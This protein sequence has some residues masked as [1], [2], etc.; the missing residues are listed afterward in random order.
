MPQFEQ[1]KRAMYATTTD[2]FLFIW[3]D[4]TKAVVQ[5]VLTLIFFK[6]PLTSSQCQMSSYT[7]RI[8]HAKITLL[9]L[10]LNG[11]NKHMRDPSMRPKTLLGIAPLVF[12]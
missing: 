4:T 2:L 3:V 7:I 12:S 6:T 10:D 8:D 1:P 9:S 11:R 5:G